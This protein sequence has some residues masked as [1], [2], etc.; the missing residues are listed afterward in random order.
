MT[1]YL[2]IPRWFYL[3]GRAGIVL[4]FGVVTMLQTLS[5]PGSFAHDA[6]LG[7]ISQVQRWFFTSAMAL[8]I[9]TAQFALVALWKILSLTQSD[10]LFGD[11][12]EKWMTTIVRSLATSLSFSAIALISIGFVAD[13]PGVVVVISGFTGL[14]GVLFLASYFVRFHNRKARYEINLNS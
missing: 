12:M 9:L 3:L 11:E 7:K 5:Y 2:G 10:H 6:A 8:W 13:D 4:L 14:I 1:E